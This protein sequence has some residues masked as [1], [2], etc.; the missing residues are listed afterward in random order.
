MNIIENYRNDVLILSPL[1]RLDSINAPIFERRLSSVIE[2]GDTRLVIDLSA[3]EY[4]SS[5]GLSVLLSAA[6][7]IKRADGSIVLAALN[8]RIMAIMKISGFNTIFVISPNVEM[9]LA[10]S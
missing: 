2:R 7:K 10:G 5:I 8:D 9:A 1:G 3:L 6:K 4:I